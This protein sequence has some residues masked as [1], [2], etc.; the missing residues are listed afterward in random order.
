MKRT[1]EELLETAKGI[2]GENTSDEALG[3]LED[4]TDTVKVPEIDWEQK[5]KENDEAWRQKY[6]DRFF[7]DFNPEEEPYEHDDPTPAKKVRFEDLFEEV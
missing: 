5:Y 7:G 4:L 1:V 3:F 2:L 6:R